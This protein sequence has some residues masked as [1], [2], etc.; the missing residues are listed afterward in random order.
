M[1]HYLAQKSNLS[2]QELWHSDLSFH[3]EQQH[4]IAE[5]F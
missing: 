3:L 1:W 2:E 5:C 4:P